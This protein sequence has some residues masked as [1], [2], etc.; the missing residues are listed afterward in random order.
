MFFYYCLST[1]CGIKNSPQDNQ[2]EEIIYSFRSYPDNNTITNGQVHKMSIDGSGVV[3]I[4][5]NDHFDSLPDVSHFDSKIVFISDRQT[6]NDANKI[7]IMNPDGG[8]AVEVPNTQSATN[9]KWSKGPFTFIGFR[10]L[11]TQSSE[12]Y[13]VN[14]DGTQLV[15][16]TFPEFSESDNGGFDFLNEKFVVFSRHYGPSGNWDILMKYLW[17]QSEPIKLTDTDNIAEGVP[18]VSRDGKKLAF[19]EIHVSQ[20]PATEKIIIAEIIDY[21]LNVLQTIELPDS[22]Q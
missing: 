11:F 3:N 16:I 12:I 17:A 7:F 20:S 9:P 6:G 2:I 19:R 4:S 5:N 18:V 21:E 13:R 14:P 8:N 15:Q 1:G 22:K 10:K